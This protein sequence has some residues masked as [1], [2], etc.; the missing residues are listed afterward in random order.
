MTVIGTDAAVPHSEQFTCL[1]WI[2]AGDKTWCHNFE[3]TGKPAGMHR[4]HSATPQLKKFKL[5]TS[6]AKV[7]LKM[8]FN[9]QGPLLLDSELYNTTIGA[10]YYCQM[11]QIVY[12]EMK[13]CH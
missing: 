10:K 9:I 13:N 2:V 4:G 1:Q 3:C 6:A 8:F 7:R 11:L 12:T 5:Q